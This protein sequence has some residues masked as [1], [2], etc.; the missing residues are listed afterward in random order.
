ML[1]FQILN[2]GKKKAFDFNI[3]LLLKVKMFVF[4]CYSILFFKIITYNQFYENLIRLNLTF[5]L[6]LNSLYIVI[7]F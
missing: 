5:L 3:Y 2:T 6:N 1:L 4:N 7:K